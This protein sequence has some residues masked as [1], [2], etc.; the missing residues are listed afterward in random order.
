MRGESPARWDRK[1][2]G[3][4]RDFPTYNASM[5]ARD[6]VGVLVRRFGL[7]GGAREVDRYASMGYEKA[8]DALLGFGP[9]PSQDFPM[10][11]CAYKMEPEEDAEPGFYRFIGHF[12]HHLLTSPDPVR[13]KLALFYLDHF[14]VT[15]NDVE[16]GLAWYHHLEML[17]LVAGMKFPQVLELMILSPALVLQLNAEQNRRGNPNENLGRELLELY[18]VGIGTYSEEEVRDAARALTGLVITDDT[19]GSGTTYKERLGRMIKEQRPLIGVG[20]VPVFHDDGEK[21]VM[22]LKGKFGWQEL[23]RH[24]ANHPLTAKHMCGKLWDFFVGGTPPSRDLDQLVS[25]YTKTGGDVRAVL[26]AMTTL[27]SFWAPGRARVLSP[28]EWTIS[29][30][31]AFGHDEDAREKLNPGGPTDAIQEPWWQVV[32]AIHYHCSQQGMELFR[33]PSVAGWDWGRGW[34]STSSMVHRSRYGLAFSWVEEP[35]GGGKWKPGAPFR[36]FTQYVASRPRSTDA[37]IVQSVEAYFDLELRDETRL[38]MTGLSK[39]INAVGAFGTTNTE[40]QAGCL[41]RM[42]EALRSAPDFHVV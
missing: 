33:P 1:I 5:Q 24:L 12:I 2:Q 9:V 7:G 13:E 23:A 19:W 30:C 15:A 6:R 42:F 38:A 22:G 3:P 16:H 20:F 21:N 39:E 25:T 14:A 11:R 36:R 29:I 40:W 34:I 31:R 10:I 37:E 27:D 8:L 18:S 26:R 17:R 28:I 32:G 35:P 4:I 41:S